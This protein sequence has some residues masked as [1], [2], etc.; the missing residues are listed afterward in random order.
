MHLDLP[1]EQL[2]KRRGVAFQFAFATEAKELMPEADDF[3]VTASHKGLHLLAQNED[4]L[5]IPGEVLREA[6]GTSLEFASPRARLIEGAQVKEPIMHLR[7]STYADF[8]EAVKQALLRRGAT[9]L[10]EH[11]RA[12]YCILRYEAPLAVLLG[13]PEELRR[14]T[15]G[16]AK[17]WI[18][19]S[20]YAIVTRDP[21]GRAA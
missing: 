16:T 8:R 2:V 21:G 1:L 15:I 17:H 3:A 19:L 9:L 20:H 4:G 10:E 14:L 6:Y 12:T 11:A 5:V 18:V 13:F 7:V